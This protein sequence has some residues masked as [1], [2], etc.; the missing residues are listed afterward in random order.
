VFLF[1]TVVQC[2]G[3]GNIVSRAA[4]LFR[5]NSS[6]KVDRTKGLLTRQ[7]TMPSCHKRLQYKWTAL[8]AIPHNISCIT[9]KAV[10]WN[11]WKIIC[12]RDGCKNSFYESI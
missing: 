9:R 11:L 4:G 6:A 12:L 3:F 10:S 8:P 2:P 1:F 7:V 5:R